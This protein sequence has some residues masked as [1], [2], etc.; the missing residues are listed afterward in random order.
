MSFRN[1]LNSN[2]NFSVL[3]LSVS[4][5]YFGNE[6]YKQGPKY[7]YCIFLKGLCWVFVC[8]ILNNAL[9]SM[10]YVFLVFILCP[11]HG[12]VGRVT[13]CR[14]RGLRFKSPCSIL[15]SRTETSSLSRVVRDGWDPRSDPLRVIRCVRWSKFAFSLYLLFIEH[16]Y[17]RTVP[18]N[19]MSVCS[20]LL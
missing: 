4:L 13:D 8:W 15:T 9:C 1:L 16:N 2:L 18:Q 11:A 19:L 5:R 7:S 20:I 17:L 3:T 6:L 10:S 14:V 12:R